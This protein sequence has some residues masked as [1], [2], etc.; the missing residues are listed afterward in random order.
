MQFLMLRVK[1]LTKIENYIIIN[2]REN[3]LSNELKLI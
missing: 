2:K 3:V 1:N